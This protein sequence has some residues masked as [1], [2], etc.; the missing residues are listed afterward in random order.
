MKNGTVKCPNGHEQM[1]VQPLVKT[2]VFRGEAIEYL[3]DAYVCEQCGIEIGTLEQTA[4]TQSAIAD[5]YRKKIGLLTGEEIRHKREALGLTQ[6]QLAKLA[7]VGEAS[8]KRWEKGTIQTKAMNFAL[9]AALNNARIGNVYTGNRALSIPRIKLV[10]KEFEI[11][12]ERDFLQE[13]DMMLYDAKYV[14]YADMLAYQKFGKSLTGSTYAALPHGPQLNNYRELVGLIGESDETTAPPLTPE[15]RKV[16]VK[17]ALTFP[18]QQLV[19]DATHRE[20]IWANKSSGS[21]IPYSD[22]SKLT[23][24]SLF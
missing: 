3:V 16:I 6:K 18:T 5:A 17:V 2:T 9:K 15:E 21:L 7:G 24:I 11:Q 23:Q 8:I 13:G 12:L 1:Q 4:K 14:W 19:Y 10:M 22:S 20:E